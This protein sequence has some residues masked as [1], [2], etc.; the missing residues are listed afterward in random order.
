MHTKSWISGAAAAIAATVLAGAVTPAS[1]TV[2]DIS[3]GPTGNGCTTC[4]GG[5]LV[6]SPGETVTLDNEG[7]GPNQL[8]LGP[9][10][11]SITN[12]ATNGNFSAWRFDSG[13]QDWAWNF[14]IGT[15]NG[16][17]TANVLDVGWIGGPNFTVP[18]SFTSQAGVADATGVTTYRF[19]TVLDSNGSTAGYHD[20]FTLGATTTLDFFVVDGF[21][22]DNVGGV[23]LNI[24]P[25]SATAA[26]PEP[27][28]WGLMIAGLGLTG[29]A[30]RRRR[31]TTAPV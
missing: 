3:A 17:N 25:V 26:V 28:T 20:T 15:D 1:A 23:A 2:V 18:A 10:T 4:F 8:T 7:V 11:Y 31:L 5:P 6:L 27:A 21:L 9:G 29:I 22:G 19:G 16:D 13:S 12:A 24:Q 14:V 30:L